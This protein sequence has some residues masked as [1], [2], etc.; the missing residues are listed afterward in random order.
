MQKI[1]LFLLTLSHF[2]VDTYATMLAPLLPLVI[3]KLGLTYAS[4]GVLGTVM[5]F[6]SLSQPLMGLWA[7]RMRRRYL[8]VGGV[9][10]A[11]VFAPMIGVAPSYGLIVLMLVLGGLGV[12]AFHPPSF[13]LAGELSGP[14]RA[15]GLSLFIFGGTLALGV[16]PLWITLYAGSLGLEKLYFVTLPGLAVAL[17]VAFSVPLDNPRS[18]TQNL[19]DV[20]QTLARHWVPLTIITV[21]VIL[22]SVTSLAFGTFLAVLGQERGLSAEE[23]GRIPLSVYQSCGVVGTLIAGYL[24]DRVDPRPLVWGSILLACP[25]LYAYLHYDGWFGLVLLGLGGAL[26]L[27]SNSVLVAMAQELT[28]ENA[29]LA[30]SLPLGFS[31]GLAGTTLPLV[32]YFADQIG[33]AETL[34]YLALLPVPTAI[35]AFFLPAGMNR[36]TPS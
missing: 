26:I 23:A 1:R 13:S 24:A 35:L 22:R 9:A 30:S 36:K 29:A 18:Q 7:D 31:W 15:F 5:S 14:R 21:V 17:L 33:M 27:S 20:R 6:A 2:L 16:T 10:L 32:G 11:A 4:A 3:A 34:K 28:P 19:A 25:V 12:S 8:V